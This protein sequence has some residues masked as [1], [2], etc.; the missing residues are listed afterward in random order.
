M[1]PPR[2]FIYPLWSLLVGRF[3]LGVPESFVCSVYKQFS[4]SLVQEQPPSLCTGQR[5]IRDHLDF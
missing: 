1:T 2:A 3:S 5:T 4:R